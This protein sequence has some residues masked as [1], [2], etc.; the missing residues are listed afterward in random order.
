MVDEF[1][2]F[3]DLPQICLNQPRVE[4]LSPLSSLNAWGGR[5]RADGVRFPGI[6]ELRLDAPWQTPLPFA[7]APR[8]R[9]SEVRRFERE[10]SVSVG[11]THGFF[12]RVYARP[13]VTFSCHTALESR[14]MQA[15]GPTSEGHQIKT[16][17]PI[18]D[19]E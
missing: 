1:A 19:P 17:R 8:R 11:R 9:V 12:A 2:I 10:R 4:S 16:R 18:S 7:D 13:R 5:I 6:S 14:L 15:I 3:H